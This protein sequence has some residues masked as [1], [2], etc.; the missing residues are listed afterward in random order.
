MIKILCLITV[1]LYVT[2]GYGQTVSDYLGSAKSKS[3]N[4]DY[5]GAKADYDKAIELDPLNSVSYINRGNVQYNLGNFDGARADYD[6]AIELDPKNSLTYNNRANLKYKLKDYNGAILDFNKSVELD[7]NN[8]NAISKRGDAK[9]N[10]KDYE[11]AIVD[12]DKTI[13]LDT[14]KSMVYYSRADAKKMLD[15]TDGAL[16]DYSKAIEVD[17]NNQNAYLGRIAVKQEKKDHQG[18]I[19]DC[20]TV[21]ALNPQNAIVYNIR[22]ASKIQ[23]KNLEGAMADYNTALEIN[24]NYANGFLNRGKINYFQKS[25]DAAISDYSKAIALEPKK[26]N[27]FINRAA[28]Y[29]SKEQFSLAIAD[30]SEAIAISPEDVD[31]LDQRANAYQLSG[32]YD[33]AVL[34]YEA[35]IRIKPDFVKAYINMIAALVRTFQFDKAKAYFLKFE[36]R[37]LSDRISEN[38]RKAF[39]FY[40][41]AATTDI[42]AKNYELALTNLKYAL[43]EYGDNPKSLSSSMYMNVLALNSYVLEKQKKLP[44][45]QAGL[46]QALTINTNQP[47]LTRALSEVKLELT[48]ISSK[49]KEVPVI[50]LLSP[51]TTG[52]IDIET[53][54]SKIQI[55]GRAKDVSGIASIKINGIVLT[56]TEKDGLFITE[57]VLKPGVNELLVSATDMQGNEASKTFMLTGV[58]TEKRGAADLDIA[59]I[60]AEVKPNYYAI[61]IA[62]NEYED[63]SIPDLKNPVKDASELKYILESQYSFDASAIDTLYNQSREVILQSIIQRSNALTE[64]DNLLIFYAGHGTAEKDRFENVDGYWIPV[65][66]KKGMTSTYISQ[67]DINRALKRS[68]AKHILLIADA[69]FSGAFTRSLPADANKH[70]QQQYKMFSRKVMTSGNLEP[71]PDNSLLLYNLK[72][73]L[74]EN[75][76]KYISAK[77][78][79]DGF[80]KAIINNSE[81]L[82]QYAAIKNVGDE[83]G[84]FIFIKK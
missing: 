5:A 24:P 28:V 43:K 77:D 10:L 67:D 54:N 55:I 13:A 1:F 42:P 60:P 62:E 53:D 25:Y 22:A 4:K 8:I 82:P 16:M 41:Q 45:A 2:A 39:A 35:A 9:L 19:E 72:K 58:R 21:I 59:P 29:V 68:N 33:K 37:K 83:G 73:S 3:K 20:N 30:L 74:K 71:V 34:D 78:L 27:P 49:D 44:E 26:S 31:Y 61:L 79:F 48:E 57:Q 81:N 66:A 64:N 32:Q 51:K 17:P 15:N 84:E 14:N 38:E 40:I 56:D 69:C 23:Q 63:A 65:S 18:V 12:Y 36:E 76:A 50:E 46:E 80:Y 75:T 52:S 47:D 6:K 7:S 70:L 11:G